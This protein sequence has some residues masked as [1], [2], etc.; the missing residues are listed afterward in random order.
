MGGKRE[1]FCN[2][3]IYI[4]NTLYLFNLLFKTP[5]RYCKKY[6][7]TYIIGNI[8]HKPSNSNDLRDLN[9]TKLTLEALN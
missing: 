9:G 7:Y 8:L 4:T 2:L 3:D 1:Q 6:I 5:L